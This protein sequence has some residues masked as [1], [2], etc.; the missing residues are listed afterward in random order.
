MFP[1]KAYKVLALIEFLLIIIG[2]FGVMVIWSIHT[3][4]LSI[5]V[6]VKTGFEMLACFAVLALFVFGSTGWFILTA[7]ILEK[8]ER[9]RND[10]SNAVCNGS[11]PNFDDNLASCGDD[12]ASLHP[13]EKEGQG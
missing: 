7:Y 12:L 8:R 6:D 11:L 10:D 9:D 2:L 3:G 13:Q 5:P 4:E 1:Y